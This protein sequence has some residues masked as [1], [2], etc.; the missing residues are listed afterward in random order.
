MRSTLARLILQLPLALLSAAFVPLSW[1]ALL[2]TD[3]A[4]KLAGRPKPRSDS[5]PRRESASVVIP[6]WNGRDLLEK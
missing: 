1:L 5:L 2:L 6:N 3:I 4:W